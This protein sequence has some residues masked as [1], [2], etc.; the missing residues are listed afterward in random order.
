MGNN[1][2]WVIPVDGGQP[3]QVTFHSTNDTVHYWTPDGKKLIFS[4]SRKGTF[5]SPLYMVGLDGKL[6][7]PMEMDIGSAGMLSQDGKVLA[8]NRLGFRYWRKHYRG[9]YNTDIWVQDLESKKITH[10]TDTNIKEFR[11]HTQDAFPMW[12]KDGM[13]YFMSEKDDIFNIWKI[14]KD[15]GEPAQVTSHKKDGI[16]YPSISPDGS[17]LIYENDFELWT[18]A[19]PDGEPQRIP[20]EIKFDVKDNLIKYLH[21][22]SEME[23]FSPSPDGS[24]LAVD[25]HGEIFLVPTDPEIGEKRQITSSPARDRYQIFS[26][27]GNFLAYIS[28]ESGEDEIWVYDLKAGKT[29]KLTEHESLKRQALWSKDSSKLAFSAANKIFVSDI[30]TGKTSELAYNPA[31]GYSLTDWSKDGKWIVCNRMDDYSNY[32]IYLFDLEKK[33]EFN[34]TQNPFRDMGGTLT[35]DNKN[36]IFASNRDNGIYHLFILPLEKVLEDPDDPLVLEKKKK[37]KKAKKKEEGSSDEAI[38]L[39]LQ[40]DGIKRRAVQ[41]TTGE[42]RV[43]SYFLS[44]DGDK[45]YFTSR[46]EKGPG[47]FSIDLR[48]KDKK[49]FVEGTFRN[50]Q[51]SADK[52]MVFFQQQNSVQK[53]PLA[54]RKKEKVKFQFAVK[55]DMKKEWTQIFEESWRV[56]KYLFYDEN[57]HGFDWDKIKTD[58]KPLLKYVGENQDL[59][60]LTNEMIGE[61]N[62]SH[63]GVSGPTRE[64][65]TT[66]RTKFIG[67]EMEPGKDYYRVSHVYWNGPADKEWIGLKKG[68]YVISIDGQDVRSGDNYWDIL[69]HALNDYVAVK[70][71]SRPSPEG[72]KSARIKTETSLRNIKYEEWV[73]ENRD[74]VEKETSGQIAYVHIRSMNRSSLQKFENEINEFHLRKGIIVDIR[75]NGGGNIDQQ[76]LDILERRPYEYWN[77]RWS[78][79]P[80]GRRPRQAI[81]GPKVMLINW[82]SASDSEVTPMGFRDLGL[83]R[84]VGTPTNGSV[85]ATGGYRLINGGR[86]RT[87]GSLVVTYD[88][89]KPNN[90]GINLENYGV[91]P[92]VWVENTPE[93]EL[94]GFDR[95]LKAAVD[96]ALRMLKEKKY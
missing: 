23:G 21:T 76:L 65:P 22:D 73:K 96:E 39:L 79:R 84:I 44:K 13:I 94:K 63:T 35:P 12:G 37:M 49:K 53:M 42:N 29:R 41:L 3:S 2:I 93:D 66:Y 91:A 70:F 45:I 43:E 36:L 7:L 54:N 51:V 95:E 92:D 69:N 61:L 86:I 28:D 75:Y 20:I 56:M 26:P 80:M 59:Y 18:L 32:D 8:F 52:S 81:V 83:G 4:T 58:Y 78:S 30:K 89:T 48:G 47:I 25:Y 90:Y 31:R 68:D 27:D 62:A 34:I 82:R 87:P 85:I 57:M 46:D 67:F 14:S 9:N 24:Y 74:F 16:Q 17:A 33:E 10:L 88:P 5:Y 72:A 6:P 1:D 50:L 55:V 38:P 19:V 60:D 11:T 77:N 64:R 15:G 71:N 40:T